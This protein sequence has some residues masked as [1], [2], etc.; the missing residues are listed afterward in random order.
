MRIE[1]FAVELPKYPKHPNRLPFLGVL[2]F[3]DEPSDK[4][5]SG[6]RGHKILL[7]RKAVVEALGSIVGMGL[8]RRMDNEG[9]DAQ[10][11][12]GVIL[13]AR[14]IGNRI[15]VRGIIYGRDCPKDVEQIRKGKFGMSF[16][17][18]DAR[19]AD[20][21]QDV[22]RLNRINFTGAAVLLAEKAAYKKTRFWVGK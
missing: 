14:M 8:C 6:A 13:K 1:C 20:M 5:P 10:R 12:I 18:G 17:I 3:V 4:A 7:E 15:V 16:E 21:R 9:H 19:V 11:K 2:G 22:W